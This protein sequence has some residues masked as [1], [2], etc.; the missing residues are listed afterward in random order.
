MNPF[1]KLEKACL[2]LVVMLAA[3]V[4]TTGSVVVT[5]VFT[6]LPWALLGSGAWMAY[7]MWEAA[8]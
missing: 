3:M 1:V 7:T 6:I 8:R 4:E 2:E 5:V